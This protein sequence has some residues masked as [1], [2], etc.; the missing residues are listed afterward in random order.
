MS[1]RFAAGQRAFPGSGRGHLEAAGMGGQ[2]DTAQLGA[3]A[4]QELPC[5]R[6]GT[7][8][9]CST[10]AL[11]RKFLGKETAPGHCGHLVPGPRIL[12]VCWLL[13]PGALLK[14]AVE[15]GGL[16]SLSEPQKCRSM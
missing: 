15:G 4:L 3:G 13:V 1:G 16:L 12:A 5:S 14:Q 8:G 10:F 2:G 11:G 9:G 7:S 6:L